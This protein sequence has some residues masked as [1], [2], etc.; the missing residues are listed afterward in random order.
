MKGDISAPSPPL[1]ASQQ[2][3]TTT[4][5]TSVLLDT[6]TRTTVVAVVLDAAAREYCCAPGHYLLLFT[7]VLYSG[8]LQ[9]QDLNPTIRVDLGCEFFLLP[10]CASSVKN[11]IY[12]SAVVCSTGAA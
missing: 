4:I 10:V 7:V 5:V 1:H 11:H 9:M 2:L 8:A 6:A 12:S 3:V